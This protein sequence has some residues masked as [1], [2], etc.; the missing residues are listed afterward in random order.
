VV[1]A[2]EAP[3][4]GGRLSTFTD[5]ESGERVDNGQHVLFGCYRQ[6]YAVL[7]EI[8]TA[9]FA[10][11]DPALALTMA[12]SDGRAFSLRCP[13]LPSPW[14]LAAG[15]LSW[16][17]VPL[18]DRLSAFRL[19]RVLAE[20]R[21]ESPAA[22]AARVDP[23]VTVTA[24]LA[25]HGQSPRLCAWLWHPLVFAALNQ[26]P[27]EASARIFVRVLAELFGS[28]AAAA[29]VSLPRVPLDELFAK[30]A[31]RYIEAHGGTVLLRSAARVLTGHDR[32]WHV[33]AGTVLVRAGA[34]ISAVPWHAM[35]RLWQEAPPA[36]V[37]DL[38]ARALKMR[39]MPIVTVNLWFDRAVMDA[40][41]VGY[42]G[43]T[44]QWMFDKAAILQDGA[45]HIAAVVSGAG[46]LVRQDNEAIT[47]IALED[48]RRALPAAREARFIRSLVVRE[49][50]ATFSVAPDAPVRP[51][52]VTPLPGFY[53]AG[54]WIDTGLPGTIESAVVSGRMAAKAV[55]ADRAR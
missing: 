3:R 48:A 49:P 41:C 11:T 14:H 34:V 7:S 28:T 39:S 20:A 13:S 47:A 19:R 4:L 38:V 8:G 25:A 42:V 17:A 36:P 54:D 37:A 21:R 27:Q 2:E 51:P 12:G 15:L 29:A 23:A 32:A 40:L 53:L 9:G 31:A 16:R 5:R 44:V 46:D 33:Q 45:Q 1:V 30:P 26:A 10:P 35:G 52:T 22:V 43:G 55:I 6:T 18:G 24:W 50:R